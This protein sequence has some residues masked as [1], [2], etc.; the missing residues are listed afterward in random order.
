[1]DGGY[2]SAAGLCS[3]EKVGVVTVNRRFTNE[4]LAKI[5]EEH[6]KWLDGDLDGIRADLSYANL[7]NT[8]LSGANLCG[9]DLYGADLRYADLS[10][11]DLSNAGLRNA[12]LRG[13]DLHNVK[14]NTDTLF[15]F[16]ACPEEGAYVGWE[17]CADNLIVKLLIPED[18]KRSSATTRKCRASKAVVLDITDISGTEHKTQAYS[19]HHKSFVYRIGE[20][21]EVKE[22]CD[23]RWNECAEGIHH[24]ITRQEAV[25]YEL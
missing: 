3:F 14:V 13:A 4:E 24:F 15:Y 7:S 23:D 17:K 10:N 19:T 8:N 11:A 16:M 21:L 22:F 1:M 2:A 9:V 12:N 20:T 25:T 18:A 5:L 6:Q